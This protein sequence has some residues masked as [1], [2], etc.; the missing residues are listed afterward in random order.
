[1]KAR[2]Y[3]ERE[4]DHWDGVTYSIESS[5]THP[6]VRLT[7]GT[8]KRFVVFSESPVGWCGVKK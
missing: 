4:I 5:R 8:N 1:M 7:F 6:K 2:A 3:I